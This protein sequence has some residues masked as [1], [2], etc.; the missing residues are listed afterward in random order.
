MI[1]S[2]MHNSDLHVTFLRTQQRSLKDS[3]KSFSQRH[4]QCW[5]DPITQEHQHE[6]MASGNFFRS[7]PDRYL[8]VS[9]NLLPPDGLSKGL[10]IFANLL[11]A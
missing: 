9:W 4:S 7:E 5:L 1:G 6:I 8:V 2:K 11:I 3:F 10:R